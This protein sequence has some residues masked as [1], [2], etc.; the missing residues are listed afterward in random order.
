[1]GDW[2][3]EFANGILESEKKT[4]DT[5]SELTEQLR[6]AVTEI[7]RVLEGKSATKLTLGEN[8]EMLSL[9]SNLNRKASFNLDAH[10]HEL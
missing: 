2:A 1:M 4:K 8:A 3:T 7:N 9:D 10:T 5:W 6:K